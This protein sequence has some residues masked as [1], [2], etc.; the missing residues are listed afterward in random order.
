MNEH[1]EN[2]FAQLGIKDTIVKFRQNQRQNELIKNMLYCKWV[3]VEVP[4]A[5]TSKHNR[6]L[7]R[8]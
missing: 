6:R 3:S 8:K 2:R 1:S 5:P 4:A 7:P